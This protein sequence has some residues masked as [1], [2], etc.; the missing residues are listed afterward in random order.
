MERFSHDAAV[1]AAHAPLSSLYKLTISNVRLECGPLFVIPPSLQC[2]P[3]EKPG[4][5]VALSVCLGSCCI[6]Q[7]DMTSKVLVLGEHVEAKAVSLGS[8]IL[9]WERETWCSVAGKPN[10]WGNV[11]FE[12]GIFLFFCQSS[13]TCPVHSRGAPHA[14]ALCPPR[15]AGDEQQAAACWSWPWQRLHMLQE[16]CA[17][18]SP[19]EPDRAQYCQSHTSLK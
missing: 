6:G 19:A 16:P 13:C 2:L 11:A 18:T 10:D 8:A 3:Q 4:A 7:P 5:V 15:L 17:H 9:L 1:Q 12:T 14:E